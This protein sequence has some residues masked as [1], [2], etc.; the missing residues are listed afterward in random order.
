MTNRPVYRHPAG[1]HAYSCRCDRC[2]PFKSRNSSV[3]AWFW[4]F[5]VFIGVAFWP[6]IALHGHARTAASWA[7][8]GTIGLAVAVFLAMVTVEQARKQRPKPVPA[9]KPAMSS[10][11]PA[12]SFSSCVHDRAEPV[13][14]DALGRLAWLCPDCGTQLGQDWEPPAPPVAGVPVA[15]FSWNWH[16]TCGRS[17]AGRARTQQAAQAAIGRG[18]APHQGYGHRYEYRWWPGL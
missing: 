1:S 10:L 18:V 16:C 7:W 8:Y 3:G 11:P 15:G 13:D 5:L 17:R 12:A 9:S 14:N 6:S 2:L 4:G